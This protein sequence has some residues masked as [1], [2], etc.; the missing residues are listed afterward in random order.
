[1]NSDILECKA[2]WSWD[3]AAVISQRLF[4]DND[5]IA[6][7]AEGAGVRNAPWATVI[8]VMSRSLDAASTT[9]DQWRTSL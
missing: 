5:I 9:T 3:G 6:A 4:A 2:D 1:M 8:P 7:E